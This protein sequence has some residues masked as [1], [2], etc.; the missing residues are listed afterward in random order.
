[1][2]GDTKI[3]ALE[4]KEGPAALPWGDLG[5]DV[6]VESTGIFTD[7]TRRRATWTRAPRRSSSPRPP[8]MR[9]SPS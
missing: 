4:V 3:K 8:A 1:M 7:A 6:V 9:T 5:V 2:V